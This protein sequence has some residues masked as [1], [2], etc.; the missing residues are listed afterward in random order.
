[1][2]VAFAKLMEKN[3]VQSSHI[4]FRSG[5]SGVPILT[6]A[7][8]QST[9]GYQTN[10]LPGGTLPTPGGGSNK[11]VLG[12]YRMGDD[13][14][15]AAV[16]AMY[17]GEI[18]GPIGL[19]GRVYP[20]RTFENVGNNVFQPDDTGM[21][22]LALLRKMGNQQF[23]AASQAPF[24]DYLAQQRL[25]RDLDE[26]SRNASISDLGVSRE[27]LRNMAAQRRQQNEDD[28][29]RK[30]LDS[31]ATPEAARKEIEDVRNANAIQ[32]A[33]KVDDREYQAKTL[34]QRIAMSR[35]ITSAVNEPLNQ[36][37][38]I[39]NP[40]PS[41]AMSQAMG[42]PGD[43]FGT[44]PL[45]TNR[46]FL[47]PDFYKKFLRKTNM[48]QESADEQTAFNQLLSKDE[49]P[50]PESGSYSFATMKARDRQNQVELV[51]EG[52]ESR[53]ESLRAR[54]KRIKKP[55]PPIVVAKK[56]LKEVYDNKSKKP[57]NDV[58]Y[59]LET[60]QEM[61]HIQL[62][63]ALNT[64]SIVSTKGYA[65][66]ITKLNEF[67]IPT[68]EVI[69]QVEGVKLMKHLKE[70]VQFMNKGEPNIEIPFA[71]VT[72]KVTS[73]EIADVLISIKTTTGLKAEMEKAHKQFMTMLVAIG[74]AVANEVQ[75][76]ETKQLEDMAA[77]MIQAVVRGKQARK[78][79]P[80]PAEAVGG[81]AGAA[82]P[83]D[84]YAS[85]TKPELK[86]LAKAAKVS[87]AGNKDDIIARLKAKAAEEE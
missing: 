69:N 44:S 39:D 2:K 16:G 41:Q 43:G 46:R 47:T 77:T 36:S 79:K 29:L 35:G 23:K 6:R 20:T 5:G 3:P 18:F 25:A 85:K 17:P 75:S 74:V 37:S 45:D 15:N 71:S 76:E 14:G 33:K 82:P 40:Q 26:V 57:G 24:E 56:I 63:I 52:L 22:T 53:L 42:R 31:G 8:G 58:L 50:M 13:D 83:L 9:T 65:E 86:A 28:Y 70:L 84:P 87:Q 19:P 51:A 66:L 4:A 62:L 12:A 30:M 72:M 60:I 27:I 55:L 10:G 81:G 73:K 34:I 54:G 64:A 61:S 80:V 49:L 78:P 48:T 68:T 1:M 21:A 67:Q 59:S 32:E 7:S 11:T 38:S